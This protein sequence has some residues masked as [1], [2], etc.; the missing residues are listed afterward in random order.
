MT[1]SHE[2]LSDTAS[3]LAVDLL[4]VL[5][6]ETDKRTQIDALAASCAVF[7]REHLP[8]ARLRPEEPHDA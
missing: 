1:E 5:L 4:R 2:P 6:R 7:F 3:D 8:A